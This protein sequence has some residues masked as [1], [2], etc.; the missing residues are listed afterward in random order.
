MVALV[1]ALTFLH[2]GLLWALPIALAPL[3]IH[4]VGRRHAAVV[5]FAAFDFLMAVTK[6]LQ[7]R[8]RLR[9]WLLIALR[10]LVIVALLLAVA[11]PSPK[12]AIAPRQSAQRR[13]ALIIDTSASMA[14]D[15]PKGPLVPQAIERA[16]EIVSHL[17]PGDAATVMATGP[18]SRALLMAPTAELSAVRTQLHALR[19]IK[20]EGVADMG[21]AIEQAAE[22]LRAPAAKTPGA[23][24]AEA[25]APAQNIFIISDLAQNSFVHLT[26]LSSEPAPAVHLIDAAG[27]KEH[28]A[29]GN[30][31][32][33][34]VSI[35]PDTA[36]AGVFERTL[37]V[38]LENFGDAAVSARAISLY[39]DGAQVLRSVTDVAAHSVQD[40]ILTHSFAAAG[41]YRL[42]V[43]LAPSDT[44]GLSADDV[45]YGQLHIAPPLRV[46]AIDG[47]PR[48]KAF[49]DELYFVQRALEA[50]PASEPGISVHTLA[51]EQMAQAFDGPNSPQ[52]CI[53]AHP[54]RLDAQALGRLV[55]FVEGGGGLLVTLGSRVDFEQLNIQLAQLL[56]HPL[57]DMTRAADPGTKA[58]SLGIATFDWT[59]PILQALGGGAEESLR[60][61]RTAQYFN[62]D[63]G[64][65][66]QARVLLRF[67]NGA[68]ALIEQ[69]RTG[70]GRVLLWT[71]SIDVDLTDL[72]LRTAFVP[73]MQRTARYLAGA[74]EEGPRPNLVW[75]GSYAVQL[76]PG[77]S[78][79]SLVSPQG[80]RL[81][82]HA[83][84]ASQAAELT[85]GP[86]NEVGVWTARL[87]ADGQNNLA[88]NF[89]ALVNPS[90]EES[91][92]T[93]IKPEVLTRRLGQSGERSLSVPAQAGFEGWGTDATAHSWTL[94]LLLALLGI[95]AAESVVAVRG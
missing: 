53:L 7:A 18:A 66:T 79:I 54:T 75:G 44:D 78:A 80:R 42:M 32:V 3:A 12:R 47:E 83:Q 19:Q 92:Y 17:S 67:D 36:H 48:A 34:S 82:A 64:A 57:R 70:L 86:L 59:H 11:R 61:S 72:P 41:A 94:W 9:Q 24:D 91:D 28:T 14:F 88:P 27:V 93:P 43:R 52:V 84:S 55:R 62:L 20:P 37:R 2:P 39:V 49:D 10:T 6:R 23:K 77:A 65:Q 16:L 74:L 45:W 40:K 63:A 68:P 30:T 89:D 31:A 73:L 76:P 51:P 21:Q 69:R 29:R 25:Q 46:V 38:R 35:S 50:V 5:D 71:T 4:W 22:Q 26:P 15:G 81:E 13:I 95:V 60:H 1:T 33:R 58:S 90:L 8:E 85:L 56:P 87:V